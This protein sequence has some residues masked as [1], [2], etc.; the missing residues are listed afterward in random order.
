LAYLHSKELVLN[1]IDTSNILKVVDFT[2]DLIGRI[3]TPDFSS[4]ISKVTNTS[5]SGDVNIN[6]HI[7]QITGDKQG[8]DNVISY[9]SNR[10]KNLGVNINQYN[11]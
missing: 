6:L 4:I 11:R 3:K 10:L 5:A 1:K 2:R 9:L 8:A 7:G